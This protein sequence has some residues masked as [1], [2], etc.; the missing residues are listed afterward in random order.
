MLIAFDLINIYYLPQYAPIINRLKE[1]GHKVQVIG[2]ANKNNPDIYNPI[3]ASLNVECLWAQND[4][5][6]CHIYRTNKPEWIFFGK[7]FDYLDELD[8]N[9]KTA[10]LGHGI[11]PKPSY[12]HKSCT[13][14][15]V[16][17]IEGSLRLEKIKQ[18]YPNDTF[19]QVGF[20]KLD[21]L[22]KGQEPGLN[23]TKLGLDPS[24]PTLLYAPTFNPSS[25]ECFPDDWP[26]DFSKYNILIKAHAISL[27]RPQY[28]KQREK[29]A[30]W[31]KYENVYVA[32][33]EELSLLPFMKNADLLISEAS[34]TLFEF[35]ALDRPVIVCNF[36]KLKWNYR[37][38]F[39]YRFNKRFGKDNVLYH[40]IGAHIQSYSALK[41]AVVEQLATPQQ[42]AA[43]RHQ[44]TRDHVGPTDGCASDR[45]IN[46]LESHQ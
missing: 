12:Y 31:A 21:P 33:S 37:G 13:P 26:Q 22:F 27:T 46:Y 8:S 28:N 38:I 43:Q 19:V 17:F 40:N 45:I 44:Y 2:Y 30:C 32:G 29:L 41:Q 5:E 42:Y 4:E 9:S 20:S 34:S 24:K 15:T 6:A 23:L 18:L 35:A 36:F 25:L 7:K 39:K 3:L 1:R 14:M 10:Q 11:G 16:R